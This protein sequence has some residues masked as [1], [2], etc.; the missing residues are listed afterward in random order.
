MWLSAEA[1]PRLIN[2]WSE[3]FFFT[4]QGV[5]TI[6]LLDVAGKRQLRFAQR[7]ESCHFPAGGQKN[8]FDQFIWWVDL[9][10]FFVAKSELPVQKFTYVSPAFD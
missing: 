2:M 1:K 7:T 3:A 6:F 9:Y 5:Y 4:G 8:W 10:A